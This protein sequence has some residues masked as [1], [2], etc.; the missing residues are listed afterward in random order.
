M[1][2]L[3]GV[4]MSQNGGSEESEESEIAM[5]SEL[6]SVAKDAAVAYARELHKEDPMQEIMHGFKTANML[7]GK[8]GMGLFLNACVLKILSVGLLAEAKELVSMQQEGY[9]M[10]FAPLPPIYEG[11]E[12]YHAYHL[13]DKNK[14]TRRI[15]E[16]PTVKSL[17]YLIRTMIEWARGGK[18]YMM[19]CISGDIQWPLGH[20]RVGM[21][22]RRSETKNEEQKESV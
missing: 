2:S 13:N 3:D 19:G 5:L 20:S 6:C 8:E 21:I 7:I 15:G 9:R 10:A 4:E 16:R 17:K 1:I 11:R 12:I 18:S 14:V 22:M